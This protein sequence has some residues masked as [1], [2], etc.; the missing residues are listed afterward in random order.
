MATFLAVPLKQTQEV[1]L[2]KPLRSFIQNTFSQVEPD[3][4]NHALNEFSK[5]RNLMIAKSVDK[6]ESALEVLYR[7]YDQLCAIENKLPIAENQIRVNFKWRNAFDKESLFGGKQILGIASGA[8]EKV[9][10]LFNIAALQSQIAEVQNHDSDEGLKTS[11]KYFQM[12]AGIFGHLKDIVLS[13]VQQEPTPD[14]SPDTLNALSALMVAQAQEAIY[15]KAAADKMK[16][17]MVAKIAHQ[18]SELF[19]DAMKLMQLASLKDLWPKDWLP[20]VAC[21]QAAYHGMAEFYQGC[22]AQQHKTYGEQIAHLQKANELLTA[23]QSR[24]GAAFAFKNEQGRIQRELQAARKDNDFIYHDKIPDL[25]TLPAIG[26]AAIAKPTAFPTKP[27]SEKFTDLFEKLVP[28]PV[29]EALS[30]FDNR[31]TQIVNTEIGRLREQT[32]LMNSILASLNLP[33]ALE[34]LSGQKVPQ[35]VI[36]KAQQIKDIGGIQF[37]NK[38]M[39]DLPELLQRNREI[40]N[41]CIKMIDDE[42]SSDKQLRE[43]FKE[44][45]SRTPSDKLTQPMRD[46]SMKY[47]QILDTAIN[48]DRIVQEKFQKH[49]QAIDLLSKSPGEIEKALPSGGGAHASESSGVV[50]K[51]R[52]LMEDVETI[53]AEREVVENEFKEAKFDMTSKFF[54]ALAS[55]GAINEEMLSASELDRIYGPLRQQVNESL[56]KQDSVM[57]QVQT[58]NM[59]F[60]QAK[61]SD[62]SGAQREAMLKDLA[63]GFDMFMELKSNLEEGTKFYNDLTPLLVRLQNKISDFCFAR[64]TEK[65]ELMTDLQKSI[66]NQPTG[67]APPPPSYQNP[68]ATTQNRAPPARPPPPQFSTASSGPPPTAT[69]PS[70][71]PSSQAGPPPYSSAPSGA[72]NAGAYSYTGGPAP[73]PYMSGSH[74]SAPPSQPASQNYAGSGQPSWGNAPYPQAGGGYQGM[75][76]PSMP[77]GFNPYNPYMQYPQ[78]P[79]QGFPNQGYPQQGYPQQY[80]GQG[81]P[82]QQQQQQYP[83]QGYQQQQYPQQ[84]QW[85]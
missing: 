58:A 84:N 10:I 51:L 66:A 39:N 64:K 63:A 32:Q 41:E 21:K 24:G 11:A 16:E 80:P 77:S 55:D 8:Y 7:Y 65:D 31:K 43:Q 52:K 74:P 35:S 85:R 60:C 2:I 40:L 1:E 30:A 4:Y 42:E 53:K 15:R 14:L 78:Q 9:C 6:H 71:A 29:Y 79:Q 20:L 57:S 56:Q 72:P 69:T 45:W 50:Q 47:K 83:Q 13:H 68:S 75:P 48:A 28:I 36:E 70:G 5:L 23:A 17:A 22:V 73:P 37:L 25:K 67:P 19:S 61:A 81:Y 3:D 27:M 34:D 18:C 38:L 59:E 82:Q 26:K 46:E 49:K 76:M 44:R 33:A 12:A 62:Q 54:S